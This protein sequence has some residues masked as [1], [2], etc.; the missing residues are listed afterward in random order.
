[1]PHDPYS[2]LAGRYLEHAGTLRGLVRHALVDRQLRV[3]LRR[4]PA[5]LLD[6]GA[7]DG[8]QSIPLAREGYDVVLLDPSAAML[9]AARRRLSGE[10]EPVRR[11]VRVVQAS[12]ERA[13]ESARSAFDAVLCHGVLM[14]L[15]D[16]ATML[17]SL[18]GLVASGGILSLL[19]KNR[20]AMAMRPGLTGEYEEAIDCFEAETSAGGLGVSTRGD[21]IEDL[22]AVLSPNGF[23]L[24]AWYGIRV[25]TDHLGDV[26]AG[27]DFDAA[28]AAEWAA[29][30]R[31]PYRGVARLLHLVAR[32]THHGTEES[33]GAAQPRTP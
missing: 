27:N 15:D 29:S 4:P 18:A 32:R 17:R 28:L 5:A 33:G 16:P 19:V 6:V 10:E 7:G 25:F 13:A 12:G 30:T 1:M 3:H 2:H 31:D 24:V 21:T 14:Y 26:P 23:V 11:R 8:R 9:D 20:Q 22:M